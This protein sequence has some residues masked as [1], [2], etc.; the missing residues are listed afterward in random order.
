MNI[1]VVVLI[2]EPFWKTSQLVAITAQMPTLPRVRLPYPVAGS[3]RAE[4]VTIAANALPAIVAGLEG[5][6]VDAS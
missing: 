4:M 3:S 6:L 2:S 5:R 1:A